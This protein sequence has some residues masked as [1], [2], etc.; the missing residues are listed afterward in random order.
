MH[1]KGFKIKTTEGIPM[2]TRFIAD[3]ARA[4]QMEGYSEILL[5]L[6]ALA[7]ISAVA[8]ADG[9]VVT[10]SLGYLYVL[11]LS[12]AALTRYRITTYYLVVVCVVLHDWLGPYEHTGW[13][14]LN[15]S[16]LTFIGFAVVVLFVGKLADRRRQYPESLIY[17]ALN[18]SSPLRSG[19]STDNM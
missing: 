16:V 3:H 10:I 11:P 5:V 8:Y 18:R 4:S 14:M 12:L 13:Q 9:L 1:E 7:G 15:R 17:K 6:A 2:R 19:S